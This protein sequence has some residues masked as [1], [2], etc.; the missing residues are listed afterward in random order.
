MQ[1]VAIR[2]VLAVMVTVLAELVTTSIKR[3]MLISTIHTETD[4]PA[5]A[6]V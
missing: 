6:I 4:I 5:R 2:A 3:I 1:V